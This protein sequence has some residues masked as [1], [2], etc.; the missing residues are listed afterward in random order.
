MIDQ[1]ALAYQ[2][3]TYNFRHCYIILLKLPDHRE[4]NHLFCQVGKDI[5]LEWR[6]GNHYGYMRVELTFNGCTVRDA[7]ECKKPDVKRAILKH[8]HDMMAPAM[9]RAIPSLQ[10]WTFDARCVD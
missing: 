1:I 2:P 8:E 3:E 5:I 7:Y 10:F 4:M 6:S 9:K